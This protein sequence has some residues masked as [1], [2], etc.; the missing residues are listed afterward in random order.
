MKTELTIEGMHCAGCAGSVERARRRVKGV[1]DVQVSLEHK[2]AVVT[3]EAARS[4]ANF[5]ECVNHIG[6]QATVTRSVHA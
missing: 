5:V 3:H 4:A 2:L 1:Q 6:L